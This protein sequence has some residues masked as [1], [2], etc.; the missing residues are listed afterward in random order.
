MDLTLITV[1][2]ALLLDHCLGEARHLHPLVGFGRLAH[3]LEQRLNSG[4]PLSRFARGLM[5]WMALTLPFAWMAA[6]LRPE[7]HASLWWDA[8]IVY[9][10][11][12]FRSLRDHT[13][14]IASALAIYAASPDE[15]SL[16]TARQRTRHI[17]SRDTAT[18]DDTQCARAAIESL[19]ENGNDSL[20]ATL[21][22]YLLLG[23]A[24][25][26][27]HRAVNTLDAL[28]G[29]HTPQYEWFGKWAA[30]A[31]D[32]MAWVPARLTAISYALAGNLIR[33]LRCWRL[34]SR[35]LSSPNGGPC[36]TAGAG[37]LGIVL[38]GPCRYHGKWLAKPFFGEGS[39]PQ[40][41]D[42]LRAQHLLA[43]ALLLWLLALALLSVA[44]LL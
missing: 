32:V 17:V 44:G 8:V 9:F 14:P 15:P 23:P 13:T 24:G 20:F 33:G 6:E 43:K 42:I 3:S 2:L 25:A 34:Q 37:S 28:W 27:L 19:L 29:Y 5:A 41:H 35:R 36:M 31:D 39:T 4:Q 30:R 18:L 38:G 11:L 10:C 12:G 7:G 22:W 40:A 26:V 21:F 16:D 1:L